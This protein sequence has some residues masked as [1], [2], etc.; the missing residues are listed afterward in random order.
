MIGKAT[1]AHLEK[2]VHADL[3]RVRFRY[4]MFR[5]DFIVRCKECSIRQTVDIRILLS[6]SNNLIKKADI[7]IYIAILSVNVHLHE[8]QTTYLG[9]TELGPYLTEPDVAQKSETLEESQVMALFRL[10]TLTREPHKVI[11]AATER[12]QDY[13]QGSNQNRAIIISETLWFPFQRY[14]YWRKPWSVL[15]KEPCF[16]KTFFLVMRAAGG[17]LHMALLANR[18]L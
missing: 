16:D 15:E 18:I 4:A 5:E 13:R 17:L 9:Q 1:G 12:I 7:Y 11:A 2:K 10:T 14:N 8:L 6:A 3:L